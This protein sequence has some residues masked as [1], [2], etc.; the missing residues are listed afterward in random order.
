MY[1]HHLFMQRGQVLQKISEEYGGV[2][3]NFSW[4]GK[5]R[6]KITF[7]EAKACVEA[8]KKYIQEIIAVFDNQVTTEYVIPQKFHHFVMGLIYSQIQQIARDYNVQIRFSDREE[9]HSTNIEKTVREN[10]EEVREKSTTD[11]FY[12]P[13]EM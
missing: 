9:I 13:E 3:I 5:L 1:H 4:S 8:A 12:F 11:S 6:N 7:K 2:I 10:E